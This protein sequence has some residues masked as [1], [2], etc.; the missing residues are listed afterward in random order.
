MRFFV[1]VSQISTW[2]GPSDPTAS[3][4]PFLEKAT[5]WILVAVSSE[6]GE[7][8]EAVIVSQFHSRT[9]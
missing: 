5:D 7:G 8:P 6:M 3:S 2:N 4:S 9:Q 1:R